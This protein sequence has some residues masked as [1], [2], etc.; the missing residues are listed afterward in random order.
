MFFWSILFHLVTIPLSQTP[1][2]KTSHG[3][4][5]DQRI[6]GWQCVQSH[7]EVNRLLR[8]ALEK[9]NHA[10][11]TYPYYLRMDFS[12][13]TEIAS[14]IGSIKKY[15]LPWNL[16]G[17]EQPCKISF[18]VVLYKNF[19]NNCLISILGRWM[20]L[21][22]FWVYHTNIPFCDSEYKRHPNKT[23]EN[24]LRY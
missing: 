18:Q 12:K 23:A 2:W 16:N 15:I 6:T 20:N 13:Y 14:C 1:R 22:A 4:S 24:I 7:K 11:L 10:K 9:S 5:T 21:K 17:F 8:I 19:K 3:H